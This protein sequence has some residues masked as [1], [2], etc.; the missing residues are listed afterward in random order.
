[1]RGPGTFRVTL[2]LPARRATAAV[3]EVSQPEPGH[4]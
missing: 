3:A 2:R 4:A 1:V